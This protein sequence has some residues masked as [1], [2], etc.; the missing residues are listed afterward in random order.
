MRCAP[1]GPRVWR[2]GRRAR[3]EDLG[4]ASAAGLH[5]TVLN[6]RSRT[7][8]VDAVRRCYAGVFAQRVATYVQSLGIESVAAIGVVIQAMVPADVAG[9][10]F[11]VNPLTGD[12]DEMVIDACYGLGTVVTDGRVTPVRDDCARP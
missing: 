8:L 7:A 6:V 10:L 12:P 2:F 3:G 4:A 11:T 5:T 9:V 1:P